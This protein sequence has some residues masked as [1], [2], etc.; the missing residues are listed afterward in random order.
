M[1]VLSC[2]CVYVIGQN[3]IDQLSTLVCLVRHLLCHILPCLVHDVFSTS[4]RR[5]FDGFC[6]IKRLIYVEEMS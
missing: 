6:L 3:R 4:L 2:Q 5:C 1:Y